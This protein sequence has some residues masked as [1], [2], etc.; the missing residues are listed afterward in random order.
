MDRARVLADPRSGWLQ[1]RQCHFCPLGGFTVSGVEAE[2][3]CE[4]VLLL[5]A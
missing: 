1:V 2:D 4:I 5:S 3:I